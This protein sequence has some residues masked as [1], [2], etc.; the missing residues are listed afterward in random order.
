VTAVNYLGHTYYFPTRKLSVILEK[1]TE[2]CGKHK[3]TIIRTLQ[4]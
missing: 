2:Q 3:L 4:S 1:I